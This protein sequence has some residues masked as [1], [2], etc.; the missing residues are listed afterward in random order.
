MI[1]HQ[2]KATNCN[3]SLN[4]VTGKQL[5]WKKIFESIRLKIYSV[6]LVIN[7]VPW[8]TTGNV[9]LMEYKEVIAFEYILKSSNFHS[10][11]IGETNTL[12][13]RTRG[14]KPIDPIASKLIEPSTHSARLHLSSWNDGGCPIKRYSMEYKRKLVD[15]L[16]LF[17]LD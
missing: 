16:L 14:S 4:L 3:I 10:N 2:S 9:N 7:S 5:N 15:L 11:G 17:C 6:D 8:L 1:W 13:V 12:T